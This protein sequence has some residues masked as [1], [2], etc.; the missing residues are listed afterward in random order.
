[1]EIKGNKYAVLINGDD[2]KYYKIESGLPLE[3]S[4]KIYNYFTYDTLQQLKDKLIELGVPFDADN[5]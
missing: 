2:V 1:M 3:F 4:D 5:L